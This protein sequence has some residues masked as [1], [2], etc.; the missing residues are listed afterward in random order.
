MA[1]TCALLGCFAAVPAA[2]FGAAVSAAV[3]RLRPAE[4]TLS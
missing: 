4:R 1:E 2:A 3:L